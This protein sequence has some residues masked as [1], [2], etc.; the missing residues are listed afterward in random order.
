MTPRR[1]NLTPE[2]SE[3]ADSLALA[4]LLCKNAGSLR[5]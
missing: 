3:F 4:E 5:L 2:A 1:A